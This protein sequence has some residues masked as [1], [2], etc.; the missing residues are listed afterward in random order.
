MGDEDVEE[1]QVCLYL[2]ECVDGASKPEEKAG[3]KEVA[4]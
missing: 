1:L 4:N 2:S 3:E